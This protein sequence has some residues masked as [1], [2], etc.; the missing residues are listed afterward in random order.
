[1]AQYQGLTAEMYRAV[2]AIVDDRMKE[3]RVVRQEFDRLVEAHARTEAALNRLSEAQART[4]AALNRLSE[5]QAQ[6]EARVRELAEAQARTEEE[7]RKYREASEARF[8]RIEA[9]LDQLVK[10]QAQMEARL[11]ELAEAQAQTEARVRELAE[12]QARTEEEFRKYREASEA[13]FARIEAVLNRLSEAQAQTE[14]ALKRLSEAQERYREASEARFARI[15]ATLNRLSEAQAQTEAALKRLSEAQAQTE[16]RVR[17]LAEAQERYR[18]AS[19]ARFARIE[20]VL[21]QVVVQ[22]QKLTDRTGKLEGR[23]LE[24]TYQQKAGSYFGHLLRRPRA[25][26]PAEI[27]DQLEGRITQEEFRE[28]LAVDL[29]VSG[30]PRHLAEAP[31]VWLVVEISATVDRHDVERARQ[32]ADLLRRAGLR[33]IPTVA[34]EDATMGALEEAKTHKVLMLQDGRSWFWEEALAEVLQ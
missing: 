12:A 14:A 26:L 13:R 1:M 29:L 25:L 2:V 28:L 11:R 19:E 34:G 31:Q 30:R 9:T 24:L 32:R 21:E 5:A 4:E 16:A 17:E 6:T 27:E 20:A 7:F 33:A 10:A 15:E 23:L 3:I 22:L 8:A 18:E